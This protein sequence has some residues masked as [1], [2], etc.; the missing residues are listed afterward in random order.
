MKRLI[1]FAFLLSTCLMYGQE[2]KVPT[3]YELKKAEDYAPYQDSVKATAQWMIKTALFYNRSIRQ[4]ANQF[5]FRWV[6][7]SPTTNVDIRPEF[8]DE[9]MSDKT[10]VF[11]Y[12][13]MMNYIAGMTLVK[14]GNKDAEDLIA[15]EAGIEAMLDGYRSIRETNKNVFLEKLLKIQE[16]G[17]LTNWVKNNS[18]VYKE[19]DKSK[20]I[21]KD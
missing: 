11:A 20:I 21:P 6:S 2:I 16:K 10:N 3:K 9:V 4:A 18:K 14:L 17:N 8:V 7:G 15:Q 19:K 1:F 12:D 13:L 5:V